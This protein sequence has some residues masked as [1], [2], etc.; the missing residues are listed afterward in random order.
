M[1]RVARAP[2]EI[3]S[4]ARL[5][6]RL[7]IR[8]LKEVCRDKKAPQ[9]ARVAAA[10]HLLD[11]GWGKPEQQI[12]VAVKTV[13]EMSDQELDTMID[14]VA[15]LLGSTPQQPPVL[16]LE[17]ELDRLDAA[18]DDHDELDEAT[19]YDASDD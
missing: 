6:T 1:P 17:A 11:R 14:R 16:E 13:Q 7:A 15:G 10:G 19:E 18:L 12:E 2:L 4:I 8:T 9:S 3:R 5:H